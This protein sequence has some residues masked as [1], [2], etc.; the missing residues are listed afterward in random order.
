[1]DNWMLVAIA[2]CG[3]PIQIPLGM[4]VT[5]AIFVHN[6][7][8]P[9][10]GITVGAIAGL[11]G[12][13]PLVYTWIVL[14]FWPHLEE[15]KKFDRDTQQKSILAGGLVGLIVTIVL[16]LFFLSTSTPDSFVSGILWA[17]YGIIALIA[18]P[19]VGIP[20]YFNTRDLL[21]ERSHR[22]AFSVPDEIPELVDQPVT[23]ATPRPRFNVWQ[24]FWQEVGRIVS[25]VLRAVMAPLDYYLSGVQKWLGIRQMGYF[26]VLPNLLIF[27]IFILLPMLLNF[28]YGFTQGNSILLENREYVGTDNLEEV[29]DCGNYTDPN[30]CREDYFWR[31]VRNTFVYVTAQVVSMV[32]L[33]LITALALNQKIVL[34]GFFRSIFFYPVL[35]SPV[36]VALIWRWFL[37]YDGGLLN[38]F[39]EDLGGSRIRFL[40]DPDN[41]NWARFWV[42][43][44]AD[45]AYMGF[46]TLILLAGLQSIPPVLYEAAEMDGANTWQRFWRVTLPLLMP[47][48]TVVL[49]LAIIRAVQAFDQVFVLT[50][51]GPGTATLFIVQYIYR[52]GFIISPPEYG[53]A[54]AASILLAGTLLI[55]TLAQLYFARRSEAT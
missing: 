54:A 30:T 3:P 15:Q 1:M 46:Y 44:V 42:I 16:L 10:D 17:F 47:T 31:G 53:M 38:T 14:S 50:G 9:S 35:L 26:F 4:F 49:V 34:R 40:S 32:L 41:S 37:K 18:G 5:R 55:I 39:I 36:V 7:R 27:S 24:R 8:K 6:Q 25:I 23:V 28:A 48:M 19:G 12:I 29:F 21:Y 11:F 51:G 45:W 52:Q 33:A 43:A 20:I 22:K 2:L 13:I